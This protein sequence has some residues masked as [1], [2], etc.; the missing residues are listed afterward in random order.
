MI[1][2]RGL[3]RIRI[4]M[5]S[6]ISSSGLSRR[7]FLKAGGASIGAL[8]LVG[9]MGCISEDQ[10]VYLEEG[11]LPDSWKKGVCRYCGTGCGME[12]GVKDGKVVAIRGWK[13]YPVNK[14]VLCLKGLSLMYVVHSKQRATDPLIRNGDKFDKVPWNTALDKIGRAHV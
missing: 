2:L 5:N 9:L 7:D 6:K 3:N 12:L 10:T 8:G 11:V 14:G 4:S 1:L 13:D